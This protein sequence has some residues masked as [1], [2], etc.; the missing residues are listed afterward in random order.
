MKNTCFLCNDTR[1]IYTPAKIITWDNNDLLRI[2][3]IKIV[4][5]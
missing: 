5:G 3:K 1:K 2:K 4:N